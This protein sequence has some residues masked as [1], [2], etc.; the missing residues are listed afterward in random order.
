MPGEGKKEEESK[1]IEEEA[2]WVLS[3]PWRLDVE[4]M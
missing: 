3:Q 2:G 1:K 4:V